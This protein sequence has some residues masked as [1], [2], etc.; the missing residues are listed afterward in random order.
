M[1]YRSKLKDIFPLVY[2]I[3]VEAE[4]SDATFDQLAEE[5]MELH[6]S[7]RGKHPDSPI[8]E[9]LEIATIAINALRAYSLADII[10]EVDDWH[11]RHGNQA[12]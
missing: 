5:V 9:W 2:G 12:R 4:G 10:Y 1:D 7:L 3:A 8:M 6:L 11:T